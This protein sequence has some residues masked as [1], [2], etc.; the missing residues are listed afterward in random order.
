[1]PARR[2]IATT[3]LVIGTAVVLA[4]AAAAVATAAA[5]AVTASK[6]HWALKL[7]V[8]YLPHSNRSEYDVVL[9]E[10]GVPWFFGGSDVGGH[11][12]PEVEY[13]N[14]RAHSAALPAG[15]HSWIAAAASTSPDD[16][17]AVTALGGAVLHWTG[18]PSWQLAKPGGWKSGTQFTGLVA[19]SPRNVW[20]FGT[21]SGAHRGAGTWHWSGTGWTQ[22]K[23]AAAV[24]YQA[25]AAGP[26]DLWAVGGIQGSMHTL[27]HFAGGTWQRVYPRSLTAFRYSRVLALGP[28]NVWV[29]GSVAG[30]PKVGHYDGHR[31]T[32]SA[33]P[34]TVT[35]TGM[36]RDGHGGLWVVGSS[37]SPSVVWDRS[38]GG[39]WTAATVSPSGTDKVLACAWVPGTGAAWGAGQAAGLPGA[40]GS[41]A[42]A[43]GYGR[44]P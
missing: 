11:G 17:W 2:S 14:S 19:L 25:S 12:A 4:T 10:A 37:G 31:W 39:T 32:V 26:A 16:I 44:V 28:A 38:T 36:C 34:G 43:Y 15:L 3:W 6:P 30:L 21:G 22:L 23:G 29:A 20:L 13:I 5:G 24:V 1:V 8:Q 42:A 33:M 41:A 18:G 27:L 40:S 35:V 7:A 9:L